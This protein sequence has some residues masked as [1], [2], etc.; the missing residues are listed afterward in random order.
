MISTSEAGEV[1]VVLVARHRDPQTGEQLAVQP[2]QER[3]V[4]RDRPG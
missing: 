1:A 4:L 3:L 2:V